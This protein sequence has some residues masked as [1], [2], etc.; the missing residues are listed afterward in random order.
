MEVSENQLPLDFSSLYQSDTHGKINKVSNGTGLH[1][2]CIFIINE[3]EV[4]LF[5]TKG[6]G[7]NPHLPIQ[8]HKSIQIHK[9]YINNIRLKYFGF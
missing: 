1:Y 2:L 6:T 8:I 9:L 7:C 4:H 3:L 5:T